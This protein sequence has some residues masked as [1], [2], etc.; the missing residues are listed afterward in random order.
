LEKTFPRAVEKSK[1]YFEFD[2]KD[3]ES[4][5]ALSLVEKWA[6]A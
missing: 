1:S 6:L 4:D 3:I 5:E 2:E